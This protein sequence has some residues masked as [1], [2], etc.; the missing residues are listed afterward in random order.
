MSLRN[1]GQERAETPRRSEA[2][3][4]P[5]RSQAMFKPRHVSAASSRPWHSESADLELSE[6]EL[7]VVLG[8][9][10]LSDPGHAPS[11]QSVETVQIV[12]E[13]PS[14]A[15]LLDGFH[16]AVAAGDYAQWAAAYQ[17]SRELSQERGMIL[18]AEQRE[19][20][21]QKRG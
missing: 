21:G 20:E 15:P 12:R 16:L 5:T 19:A 1:Q 4:E 18:D 11:R 8:G 7:E 3:I 14:L 6:S 9:Q 2:P 17:E 10:S 13:D